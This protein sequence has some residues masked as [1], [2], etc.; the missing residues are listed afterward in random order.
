MSTEKTIIGQVIDQSEGVL[1]KAYD[2]LAHPT[3]RSIGN[4]VSLI[5]RTIGVWLGKWEKWVIN[6]EESIRLTSEAVC[7]KAAKIPEDKLAEPEPYVAIP[8]IQQL[9]YCYNSEG[10]RELYANLLVASMNLDTKFQVHP[11]FVDIIKQLS[12]ADVKIIE[13]MKRKQ[14]PFPI[15][16]V[17]LNFEETESFQELLIDYSMDLFPLFGNTEILCAT[18]QNLHRLA[19]IKIRYDQVI[20][21]DTRYD[22]IYDDGNYK[23]LA[24]QFGGVA[25]TNITFAK[26]LIELTEY[27]K[28]F[29]NVCCTE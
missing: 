16:T 2:D 15:V 13:E 20:K 23:Q 12:P 8:V 19:I 27:G 9:G 28:S 14:T 25:K 11:S 17:K 21:P 22:A 3:V 1:E 6:G 5:P 4:T 18:L 7:E 10:L 26:G 24:D 29:C